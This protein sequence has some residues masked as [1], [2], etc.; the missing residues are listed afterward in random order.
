MSLSSPPRRV[1][2]IESTRM[3][4]TTTK[5]FRTAA[6]RQ[7]GKKI[8]EIFLRNPESVETKL[9]NFPK[10]VRRQHLKRFLAMYETFMLAMPV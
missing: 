1:L 7:A 10:Y 4:Q 9:E 2:R 3:T 8:E 6:E 5:Q